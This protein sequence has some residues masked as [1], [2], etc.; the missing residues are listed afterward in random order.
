MTPAT[1]RALYRV[2]VRVSR[3]QAAL[4]RQPAP[5]RVKRAVEHAYKSLALAV[6][7]AKAPPS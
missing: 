3:L 1:Q 4:A 7:I 6:R 2:C 5:V